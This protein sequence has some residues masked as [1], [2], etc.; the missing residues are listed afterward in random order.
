M[1]F[2]VVLAK[3]SLKPSRQ[4]AP[5]TKESS[6]MKLWQTLRQLFKKFARRVERVVVDTNIL[7]SGTLVRDGF[8]AR[9]IDAAKSGEI[10]FVVSSTLIDEY[11][12]VIRRPRITRRYQKIGDRVDTVLFYMNTN[13]LLVEGLLPER[14]IPED[15]DDDF[16]IACALEGKAKYIISGDEHLLKLRRYRGIQILTPR[17]FV[18]NVLGD[19]VAT[20]R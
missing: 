7:I 2:A 15:P 3:N 10:Q 5:L 6:K 9:I 8:P 12:D 1:L 14:V 20:P 16:L 11:V 17:D 13:A 4:F 19:N 18:V